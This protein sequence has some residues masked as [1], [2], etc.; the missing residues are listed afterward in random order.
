MPEAVSGD[1]LL[2]VF[3]AD[4]GTATWTSSGW[5]HVT[6]S[7]STNTSQLVAMW[8]IAGGSEPATYTFTA[9]VAESFNGAIISFEI[10]T[11]QTRSV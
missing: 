10:R 11:P 5:T 2:A 6:G 3:M 1:L 8:R 9:S 7:P 4:T